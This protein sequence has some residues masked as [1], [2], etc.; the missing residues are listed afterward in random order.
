MR[1]LYFVFN[2]FL[3]YSLRLYF[4]KIRLVNATKNRFSSTIFVSNHP[5]AFMDPLIVSVL[6]KPIIFFMTR[7][8]VFTKWTKPFLGSA[9]M[10]PIY[11]Q[12]D[13]GN[14]TEKN[15]ASFRKATEILESRRGLLI[16]GEGMTNDVFE[17]RM[18][19]LKKGALRIGFAALEEGNWKKEI[20]LV[21]VGC[22][23]S[24][25][26]VMRSDL[27]IAESNPIILNEYKDQYLENPTRTINEL[28]RK[29]ESA[30]MGVITHI[31]LE[32]DF[33]FHEQIMM[34]TRKGMNP[35]CFDDQIS[36]EKRWKYSKELAQFLNQYD[37]EYPSALSELRM[38]IA[39]Y[40]QRLK[41][42][43]IT[44]KAL[45]ETHERN[46]IF[47]LMKIV[48]LLPFAFLGMIHAFL[49]T[50]FVKRF[51]EKTFKRKV[52]WNSTKMVIT[53]LAMQLLNLPILFILPDLMGLD[54][55]II[56]LYYLSIGLLGLSWYQFR[57]M[58]QQLNSTKCSSRSQVFAEM[59]TERQSLL[60]RIQEQIHVNIS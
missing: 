46:L 21:A 40:F 26:N 1:F 24:D 19:P 36:L 8:D 58:I 53:M 6:R 17:R 20:R 60:K 2:I 54:F 14:A 44:E 11:R 31:K 39:R 49:P 3:G 13:G 43:H 4:R 23:Y 32:T 50:F 10:I 28:N 47:I 22:N 7:S 29:L 27:L 35:Y 12:H 45:Y 55:W 38:D 16:F 18:K 42:N 15:I 59:W 33:E 51:V 57:R 56:F 9:H 25:P 30:L 41:V 34:L 52:F 48:L 5:S 37:G